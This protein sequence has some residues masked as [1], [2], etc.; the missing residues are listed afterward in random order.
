MAAR[1]PGASAG[2]VEACGL[3]VERVAG[4]TLV[5]R[6]RGAW[7]VGSKL[8]GVEQVLGRLDG[9]VRRIALDGSGISAWDTALLSFVVPL[10]RAARERQLETDLAGLPLGVRRLVD[11]A[12]TVAARK[13][14][15]ATSVRQS[16]LAR[17]GS[18]SL[19]SLAGARE[20][21]TF[22]GEA[23][24]AFARLFRGRARFRRR[25]LWLAMQE[26][27]A[28]ALGI[29]GLISFLIGLILA[30]MGAIQLQSFGA[31]LF[32]ADLVAIGMARE[33]SAM[34][35][36]IVLAGRTGAAYAAELGTMTVNEEIDALRTFG[37]S[38]LDFL[39][40]PRML[41]LM[42]MTPL[43][44][45]YANVLGI[46]GGFVVGAGL[47]GIA[48]VLYLTETMQSVEVA[49]FAVGLTKAAVVGALVAL[50]G[51]MRGMQC[52][53]SAEAVG[54]ATTSAVVTGIVMIIVSEA[55]FAV[56]FQ[57][58]GV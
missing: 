55:V 15:P 42:L 13:R 34:M 58:L 14:A 10:V 20:M 26:C 27:G 54:L 6:L 3:D 7:R 53:R 43:L 37:I 19:A 39:V 5:V 1:A 9:G 24:L 33:M 48:P 38:P 31:E 35:T 2:E 21:L 49:D 29:V 44:A 25:D 16:W 52:G 57:A 22:L 18:D 23:V 56:V 28:R 45:V 11:L 12:F 50:A 47:L 4:D 36:G 51:C 40:L 17:V 30:F 41:A 46:L 8:P 32:V